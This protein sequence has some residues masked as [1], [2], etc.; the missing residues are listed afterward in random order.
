MRT[1]RP[2]CVVR[3]LSGRCS[4][5]TGRARGRPRQRAAPAEGSWKFAPRPRARPPFGHGPHTRRRPAWVGQ[6]AAA[7]AGSDADRAA[8]RW[9]QSGAN[10]DLHRPPQ[11]G[12]AVGLRRPPVCGRL[13]AHRLAA[14]GGSVRLQ[15][16]PGRPRGVGLAAGSVSVSPQVRWGSA[17]SWS[18]RPELAWR[19]SIVGPRVCVRHSRP[20]HRAE[21]RRSLW[22]DQAGVSW[23][24]AVPLRGSSDAS[25]T[26]RTSSRCSPAP[27]V[28]CK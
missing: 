18:S 4:I 11:G 28:R 14:Q 20:A 10:M 26:P 2:I 15:W 25:A 19:P 8:A 13:T 16:R 22:L 7:G 24:L 9:G 17:A 5:S 27:C 12:T 21:R 3:S 6:H 1:S 23:A